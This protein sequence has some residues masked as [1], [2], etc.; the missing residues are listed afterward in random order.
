MAKYLTDEHPSRESL[1]RF[2]LGLLGASEMERLESHL[3]TCARCAAALP[4]KE[5]DRL[6]ELLRHRGSAKS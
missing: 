1:R 5:T 2:A 4:E 6:I 3:R